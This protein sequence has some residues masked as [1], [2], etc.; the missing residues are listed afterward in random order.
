M[1]VLVEVR[2]NPDLCHLEDWQASVGIVT[3]AG[4][5]GGAPGPPCSRDSCK[6]MSLSRLFPGQFVLLGFHSLWPWISLWIKTPTSQLLGPLSVP[7]FSWTPIAEAHTCSSVSFWQLGLPLLPFTFFSEFSV[8][9]R[10]FFKH[11]SGCVAGRGL[12]VWIEAGTMQLLHQ[13]PTIQDSV[14]CPCHIALPRFS[15]CLFPANK[16]GSLLPLN[17]FRY[18]SACFFFLCVYI[19]FLSSFEKWKKIP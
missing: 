4:N 11:Y 3:P 8:L 14:R 7:T 1:S 2:N 9:G 17:S 5:D 10:C 19:T 18:F 13:S 6:S 15:C 12:A 16:A